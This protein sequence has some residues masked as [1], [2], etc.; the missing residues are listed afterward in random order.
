MT[1]QWSFYACFGLAHS[2][3]LSYQIMALHGLPSTG[4]ECVTLESFSEYV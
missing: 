2:A 1:G 4:K 3:I